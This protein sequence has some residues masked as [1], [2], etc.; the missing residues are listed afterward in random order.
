MKRDD[1][2]AAPIIGGVVAVLTFF[3]LYSLVDLR[4]MGGDIAGVGM[5][6]FISL[7]MAVIVGAVLFGELLA[8]ALEKRG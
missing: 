4:S 7:V 5:G 1:I 3:I 8:Q 6:L 2:I